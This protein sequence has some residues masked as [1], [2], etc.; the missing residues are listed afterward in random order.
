MFAVARGGVGLAATGLAILIGGFYLGHALGLS[1]TLSARVAM[2]RAP[3]DNAVRGGDQVAQA[4][5]ALAAGGVDGTGA[6]LGSTR[7][8]PAGHTD[9]AL[10]SL[11]EEFGVLGVLVVLALLSVIVWRGLRIALRAPSDYAFFLTLALTLSLAM[12]ALVMAAGLLG[13]VPLTGLVTPF[14]SYGGSAMIVNF[15]ALGLLAAVSAQSGPSVTLEPFRRSIR[16][17]GLGLGAAGLVVVI[18]FVR[19]QVL[20]AD[21]MLVRP[22]L[23]RQADGGIRYQYNP[24]VLDAARQLPRGTIFDRAGLPLATDDGNVRRKAAEAYGKVGVSIADACP[25]DDARCYPL[26]RAAFHLLG[27]ART[28][29]N[30]AAPNTSYVERDAEDGLRGFDDRATSVRAERADGAAVT[31]LRR[32]YRDLVPLVRHR[33]EPDRADVRALVEQ[34]RDLQLSIDAPLQQQ[35]AAILARAARAAGVAR[36]AAVV[37]DAAT[38]EILASVSYPT[39]AADGPGRAPDPD[40]LLDRARYGLYPPGSTFKLI[41]AAAA[42][43]QDVE[44][45]HVPLVCTRLPDNRVGVRIPG[46][47]P[48]IRDD[49]HD[50]QPHGALTMHDG[51]VRSCNAYFAQLAVRLGPDV[52]ART[53]EIAGVP[54]APTVASARSRA[55]LPHAGYGQGQVLATPLRMARIAAAMGSDG[56]IRQAPIVKGSAE[57]ISTRLLAPAS[58]RLLAGDMRDAVTQGT[59]RLLRDH[60]SRI[61]GKTGT[62]EVDDAASH[63]WFVGFAPHGAATRRVAFA[64]VM[65]NAGYGGTS[66]AAVAGQLVTAAAARGLAK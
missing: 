27:D 35:A 48:A 15:A 57:T 32:D 64:V 34:S 2:W 46:Y 45:R 1:S 11:G 50:R 24:R 66:A 26:G 55:E 21:E 56:V 33:W 6:G 10:A 51:V 13:L 61:A 29:L 41:T 42:L 16:T 20:S 23:S 7:F 44:W 4:A 18:L 62:A 37:L 54:I 5:W 43:Q 3:W 63:G 31:A 14:L 49:I 39:P 28:R 9:L 60:P 38:G 36:A 40:A 59:G 52:L 19:V 53:A 65:E 47:G 30:W 22:Q 12:P 17:L 25:D 58:A 8:L